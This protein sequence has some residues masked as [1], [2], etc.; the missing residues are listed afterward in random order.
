MVRRLPVVQN[1]ASEDEAAEQ[2]PRSHWV[3]IMAGFVLTL[4]LPLVVLA[5]MLGRLAVNRLID[6]GDP[7][8]LAS[9]PTGTRVAV[10]IALMLPPISSFAIASWAAGALVGRF[11]D[12]AGVREAA[13]GAL[14]AALAACAIALLG[15][16]LRPWPV[17]LGSVVLLSV[18]AVS[19][20]ALGGR[21]G[22]RKRPRL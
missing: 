1:K 6:A 13:T 22:V 9:A 19:F 16:A 14:F 7:E 15:G 5:Q 20:G 3:A 8:A 4:W 12:R 17:L 18:I 11:G 2:R 10:T 21:F